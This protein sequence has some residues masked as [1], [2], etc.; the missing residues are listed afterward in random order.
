MKIT[1]SD[2]SW[3]HFPNTLQDWLNP[4]WP[5]VNGATAQDAVSGPMAG[6]FD[7][8]PATGRQTF[9][10]SRF[11]GQA[12]NGSVPAA[13]L[14]QLPAL[15]PI[16]PW[17]A[18]IDGSPAGASARCCDARWCRCRRCCSGNSPR[19]TGP[20]SHQHAVMDALLALAH[21]L[22]PAA[23]LTD[24]PLRVLQSGNFNKVPVMLGSNK[25]EGTIFMPLMSLIVKR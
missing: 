17:A 10:V 23:G 2:G 19:L 25:N 20:I 3:P 15:A 7:L 16:M 22:C 11:A 9:N 14:S 4:N 1:R 18:A 13:V 8:H 12:L 21:L 6:Y 5:F 24:L